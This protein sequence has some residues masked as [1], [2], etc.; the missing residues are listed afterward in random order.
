MSTLHFIS[1]ART[2][3]VHFLLV[4]SSA[5]CKAISPLRGT[6]ASWIVIYHVY[7]CFFC[8]VQQCVD[9][10]LNLSTLKKRKRLG[11]ARCHTA[12]CPGFSL[13]VGRHLHR[14]QGHVLTLDE[15]KEGL[16]NT[17]GALIPLQVNAFYSQSSRFRHS[18][19]IFSALIH[20]PLPCRH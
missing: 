6:P 16:S 8:V 20:Q 2:L 12:V 18:P 10:A 11:V 3:A 19:S 4:C 13:C 7:S 14:G 15:F 9:V 17:F 5:S 1:T